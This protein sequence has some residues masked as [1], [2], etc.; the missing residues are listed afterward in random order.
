[1]DQAVGE[2][3]VDGAVQGRIV[4]AVSVGVDI[5][6]VPSVDPLRFERCHRE[7]AGELFA[8]VSAFNGS[9]AKLIAADLDRGIERC[10]GRLVD[11]GHQNHAACVGTPQQPLWS[12]QN[13]YAGQLTTEYVFN[14]RADLRRGGVGDIDPVQDDSGSEALL[15]S[16]AHRRGLAESAIHRHGDAGLRIEQ[17]P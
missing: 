14:T 7:R 17:R 9:L 1:M 10:R 12:A 13:L 8:G 4:I 2:P 6:T 16:N 3:E 11:C 5:V 15:A